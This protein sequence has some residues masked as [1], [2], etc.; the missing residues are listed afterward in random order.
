MQAGALPAQ[1]TAPVKPLTLH[2]AAAQGDLATVIR[3]LAVDGA[4][5]NQ[6][7]ETDGMSALMMAAEA[8]HIDIVNALLRRPGIKLDATNNEDNAALH[9]AAENNQPEIVECLLEAGADINLPSPTYCNSPLMVATYYG[10]VAVVNALLKRP[11]IKVDA[12]NKIGGTALHVALERNQPEIMECLLK[13]GADVNLPNLEYGDTPLIIATNDGQ[14]AV[15][16]A[17]LKRPGIKLDAINKDGNTALHIAAGNNQPEIAEC[18]LEAGADVN[19]PG[20][21]CSDTALMHAALEGHLAV[22]NVL[23][24]RPDIKLNAIDRRGNTALFHAVS[25]KELDTVERL[26]KA[27]ADVNLSKNELGV[28][29]LLEAAWCGRVAVVQALLKQPDIKRNQPG[30]DGNSA[31]HAAAKRNKPDMVACLLDAGA[32]VNLECVGTGFTSLIYAAESGHVEVVKL[33][34]A[35]KNINADKRNTNDDSA[36]DVALRNK[37]AAVIEALMGH[38]AQLPDVDF[39]ATGLVPS[40]IT[41][42]DLQAEQKN[43][44][45]PQANPLGLADPQSLN[46]A[47]VFIDQ[48]IATIESGQDVTRWLHGKGIRLACVPPIMKCLG[49]LSTT[50]R[51]LANQGQAL[52]M[53]QKR[54]SCASAITR[55]RVQ[56]QKGTTANN[57][58]AAGIST[59]GVERLS[60]IADRQIESITTLAEQTLSTLA[61][62]MLEQLIPNCL[63]K[64]TLDYQVDTEALTSSLIGPGFLAP[65]A[66]AIATIWKSALATLE[67]QPIIMPAG[68]TVKQTVQY[69]LD[70]TRQKAPKLFARAMQRE[71][72]SQTLVTALRT[73]IGDLEGDEVIDTLF[74]IQCDQLRQYCS[75]L[76]EKERSGSE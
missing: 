9:L 4:D 51:H 27:G 69:L 74:Q 50:W 58:K 5:V 23:L 19:P 26:L 10:Q 57:Y 34:L 30:A 15:V 2:D 62:E 36:I 55:L 75:Q 54:L 47:L 21:E 11:G 25:G 3:I 59:T 46:R 28:T 6:T 64:T 14:L 52:T 76:L 49:S 60:L 31:L 20:P 16:N 22:V 70:H 33:L 67:A 17:L 37:H 48:L 71:L 68:L 65:V 35:R 24:K 45:D 73:L 43:A 53:H 42:A 56:V 39:L 13:A 66:Q 38:G 61:G 32:K 12:I 72:R 29:P 8:G 40:T 7:D 63:A 18:L 1:A 41:L 44:V